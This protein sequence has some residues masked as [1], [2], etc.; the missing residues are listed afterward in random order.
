MENVGCIV[1]M[2]DYLEREGEEHTEFQKM[3]FFNLM[4]HEIAHMWFG[5]LVTMTW[6]D[7]LWLNESFAN[8]ISI[9]CLQ[10]ILEKVVTKEQIKDGEMGN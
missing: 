4:L 8:Y 6:W 9:I 2:D 5:N 7:D 1:I 3:K 10:N